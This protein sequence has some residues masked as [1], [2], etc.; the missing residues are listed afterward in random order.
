MADNVLAQIPRRR[1]PSQA[2]QMAQDVRNYLQR[3]QSDFV[4]SGERAG[5]GLG[6]VIEDGNYLEGVPRVV[7]GGL[8]AIGAPVSAAVSPVLGPLLAPVGEAVDTYVG[9]PIERGTGYPADITNDIFLSAATAGLAPVARPALRGAGNFLATAG[10]AVEG[11]ANRAGYTF[12]PDEGT[13]FTFGGPTAL[14]ADR[15]ALAQFDSLLDRGNTS[16][17]K[18][19]GKTGWGIA[20]D[21]HRVFEID[22]SASR[23]IPDIDRLPKDAVPLASVFQHDLLF[24][25]YPQLSNVAVKFDPSMSGGQIYNNVMTIGTKGADANSLRRTI[26]HEVNHAVQSIE[27]FDP[28]TNPLM[29]GH[30]NYYDSIGET[31]SRNAEARADLSAAQRRKSYPDETADTP[32]SQQLLL[33]QIQNIMERGGGKGGAQI[34]QSIGDGKFYLVGRNGEWGTQGYATYNE[35]AQAAQAAFSNAGPVKLANTPKTLSHSELIARG[36]DGYLSSAREMQIPVAKVV[37]REP[38]PAAAEGMPYVKGRPITQPIEV[39]YNPA[40]DT[41]TLYAGNHRI[42]QAE[43]NGDELI[44]AFV[45]GSGGNFGAGPVKLAD[46]VAEG[47]QGGS[48]GGM[49]D[50]TYSAKVSRLTQADTKRLSAI[51]QR[52][53]ELAPAGQAYAKPYQ[54]ALDAHM[55]ARPAG[56]PRSAWADSFEVPDE[57]ARLKPAHDELLQLKS[58]RKAL[59]GRMAKR[60]TLAPVREAAELYAD[61]VANMHKNS[62]L[63]FQAMTVAEYNAAPAVK[64]YKSPNHNGRQSSEYKVIMVNGR[65]AYAR[66]SN[67]WG[68][69]YTNIKDPEQAAAQ[70]G[71]SL[72]EATRLAANDPFGRIGTKSHEWRLQGGKEGAN[73]SQAGYVFL[74]E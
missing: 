7:L 68:K 34:R 36:A 22:D 53:S 2:E 38:T 44:P 61:K 49:G 5:Q 40:D 13:R 11:A 14:T 6:Q 21:G 47:G 23:I 45:Q 19:W 17:E 20:P 74:D 66:K 70:L 56:M 27:G 48:V 31:A 32:R 41:Y 8:G 33:Q 28:G 42:T 64:V 3:L 62:N 24:D 25:A 46:D 37:G 39:E 54:Q 72:E 65:P 52:I 9:Q 18:M 55:A 4:A 50:S 30:A 51:D 69:F 60:D 63:E 12:R 16:H 58:E 1:Y 67:H 35:A 43:L 29:V 71:I 15:A 57:L 73:N 26:I 59:E 10:D